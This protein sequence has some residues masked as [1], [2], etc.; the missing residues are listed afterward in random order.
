[1]V[2]VNGGHKRTAIMA[3]SLSHNMLSREDLY[4]ALKEIEEKEGILTPQSVVEHARDEKSPLHAQFEWDNSKA[5]D[6]YRLAQARSLIR[7][8]TVDW[9][10]KETREFFNVVVKKNDHEE[11]GYVSL[12]RVLSSEELHKQVVKEAFRELKYWHQKYRT[13]AEFNGLI[14]EEKLEEIE[15]SL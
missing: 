5:A 10:G 7:E 15:K 6:K 8:I 13:L 4:I 9:N 1:M 2:L 11:R 12:Q 3:R 14:S